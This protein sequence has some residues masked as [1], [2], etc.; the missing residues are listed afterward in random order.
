MKYPWQHS[1]QIDP[2]GKTIPYQTPAKASRQ[3]S[4]FIR[5]KNKPHA[6]DKILELQENPEL[7]KALSII[8]AAETGVFSI[9]CHAEKIAEGNGFRTTGYL[10]FAF[11]DQSLVQDTAHYFTQFFNFYNHLA[12]TRFPHPVQFDWVLMPAVFTELG[13]Q[14]FS[15]SVKINPRLCAVAR[16]SDK[17]WVQACSLTATFLAN[18]KP[19]KGKLIY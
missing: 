9:G 10:E 7:L 16:D 15:C 14:G 8:N 18:I 12:R 11:N 13:I 4:P 5:L 19:S 6:L 2:N 1:L 17:M 3:D